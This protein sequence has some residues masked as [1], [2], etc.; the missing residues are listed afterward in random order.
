MSHLYFAKGGIRA[1]KNRETGEITR[2]AYDIVVYSRSPEAVS[3]WIREFSFMALPGDID[4]YP[5]KVYA[6]GSFEE[7]QKRFEQ[8]E[9][10]GREIKYIGW[11][12]K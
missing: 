6:I 10:S 3:R 8:N 11:Y 5:M 7:L 1:Q 9:G 12:E 2:D 4:A